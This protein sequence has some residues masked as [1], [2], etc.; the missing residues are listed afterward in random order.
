MKRHPFLV[1]LPF[2]VVLFLILSLIYR[3]FWSPNPF[4]ERRKIS[5]NVSRGSN[6]KEISDSLE[7]HGVIENKLLFQ[8][9]G[10][11]IGWTTQMKIGKYVFTE[12]MSNYEILSD[13]RTGKS[14]VA[15]PVT[16]PEGYSS[17]QIAVVFAHRIGTDSS[18]FVHLVRDSA[19]ARELGF[20]PKS[21]GSLEGYLMP[22]TYQFY[23]QMDEHEIIRALVGHTR[24][25]LDDSLGYRGG[26]LG[27][28]P[29]EILTIASIV[30]REAMIDSERAIIAGVF[31]NRLRKG[32]K[33]EADPTIQFLIDDGPRRVLYR[34]LTIDSPYNTYLYPGLPPT[35]IGNPGKK[36]I[37][38][39]LHP[40]RHKYLYFVS[41]GLG[42]HVFSK[43]YEEHQKAVQKYRHLR[44]MAESEESTKSN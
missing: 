31:Y 1:I 3:A 9:A 33:L 36:S 18:L 21:F 24:R 39:A 11:V 41:N 44:Q 42:G 30:E 34:D 2:L 20:D 10:R 37:L 38:A 15:I 28:N 16:I 14:T 12:G 43:T 7:A 6:F 26:E 23:W 19:F 32:M 22:D 25:F 35:P 27:L 5:I 8:L 17:R 29:R 4:T 13:L 40:A